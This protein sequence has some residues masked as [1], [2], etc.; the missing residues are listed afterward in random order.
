MST[1]T[2][3][4]MLLVCAAVTALSEVPPTDALPFAVRCASPGVVRCFGFDTQAETEPY[5]EAGFTT[6]V[7]DTT[8]L[9]S[10]TGSL[11]MIVPSLS[12]ANTSGSFSMN[13][14]P[15]SL[16]YS[17]KD[18]YPIQ[19]GPGQ[20]FYVQWRQRFSPEF[21]TTVYTGGGGWKQVLIGEG[22]RTGVPAY[23]CTDIH[24]VVNRYYN[25][26]LPIA[27]H[28]CG[29]KDGQYEPLFVPVGTDWKLQNA[30][31]SPFCLR[32]NSAS[33]RSTCARYF[34][35]E[36][37]TFQMHIKVGTPYSNNGVYRHDS[38]V[39]LWVAREG[40]PSVL[41][42]D[43]SQGSPRC[44]AIQV[45]IPACQSGYDLF[46]SDA[47]T[48]KYGKVWLTPYNTGKDPTQRHPTAYTWYDDLIISTQRI[49][50]P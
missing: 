29:A 35:N 21:L 50:D 9:A 27:Y 34:P 48:A 22:D 28:S 1:W 25:E 16:N 6:P 8:V 32:S 15:G 24:V 45:S 47:A 33:P 41:I 18:P 40:Q 5:I 12:P 43:M 31:P 39:Q 38:T 30:R 4:R 49:S 10:G 44:Q 14:T 11:K 7:V 20:E 46:N 17:T 42:V 23:S 3:V 19:F 2:K 13:F 37:M 36:W 26:N